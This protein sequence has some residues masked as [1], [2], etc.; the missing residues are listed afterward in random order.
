MR[1]RS[2]AFQ[3]I[4]GTGRSAR[5]AG[6]RRRA[7]GRGGESSPSN[8]TFLKE[9]EVK[10]L[11][12]L[13]AL[14]ALGVT[15]L[16]VPGSASAAAM[17]STTCT[18]TSKNVTTKNVKGFITATNVDPSQAS[19]ATCKTARKVMNKML[20]LRIE[21]PKVYEGFRCTPNVIQTEPD[22]VMYKC[23]FKGADTATFIKLIFT[24]RYDQD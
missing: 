17:P 18:T 13:A 24:A 3:A 7:P 5:G 9:D 23:V 8:Q 6:A 22:V 20:S 2:R 15:A 12:L 16:A 21:E 4:P 11:A 1:G 14:A 19:F 10:R